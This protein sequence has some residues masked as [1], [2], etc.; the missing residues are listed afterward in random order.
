MELITYELSRIVYLTNVAR[1]GG[2]AF[3]PDVAQR[4]IQKYSFVKVPNIDD[5]RRILN[6]LA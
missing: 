3:W 5:L 4:V 2:G 6:P 1:D